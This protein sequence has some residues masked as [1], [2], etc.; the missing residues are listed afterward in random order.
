MLTRQQVIEQVEDWLTRVQKDPQHHHRLVLD[1]MSHN[2][3]G[4]VWVRVI[5]EWKVGTA[6]LGNDKPEVGTDHVR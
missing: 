4:E 5:E 2:D 3:S 6:V 1:R